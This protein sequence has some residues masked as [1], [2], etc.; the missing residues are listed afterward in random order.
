MWWG[1]VGAGERRRLARSAQRD[2]RDANSWPTTR[3]GARGTA[4]RS[5][6]S[7]KSLTR[8]YGFMVVVPLERCP[9]PFLC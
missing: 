2:G 5:A 9:V 3:R 8:G 4:T 1:G 7:R 6:G